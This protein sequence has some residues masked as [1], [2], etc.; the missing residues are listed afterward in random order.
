VPGSIGSSYDHFHEDFQ[1]YWP[2]DERHTDVDVVRDGAVGNGAGRQGNV[3]RRRLAE[4][5]VGSARSVFHFDVQVSVAK[6]THAGIPRRRCLRQRL[7]ERVRFWPFDGCEVP[8]GRSAIAEIYPAFWSRGFARDG[9]T[10]DQHDAFS[11]AAWLAMADRDG[12][13]ATCLRPALTPSERTVARVEGSILAVAGALDSSGTV[14]M[15]EDRGA[16][17]S[18]H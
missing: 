14:W 16:G 13:L 4:L 7:V 6:S 8:A 12:S 2:T 11:I 5:P 10:G 18:L 1:R 3:R 9:R 15:V 17:D